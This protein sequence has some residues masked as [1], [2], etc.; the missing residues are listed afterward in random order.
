MRTLLEYIKRSGLKA[1]TNYEFVV[2]QV[3]VEEMVTLSQLHQHTFDEIILQ[4]FSAHIGKSCNETFQI[5]NMPMTMAKQKYAIAANA[6]ASERKYSNVNLTEE[7]EKAGLMM[8]TIRV[9]EN[10]RIVQSMSFENIDYQEVYDCDNWTDSRLYEIFSNRFLFVVYKA[11]GNII[12]H[13][14]GEEKEYVLDDV[15]FWT[16]PQ[17]D[18][19]L[20]EKY[21]NDIRKHVLDDDITD[22]VFWKLKDKRKFHVRPKGR[23]GADREI[24][25]K[26]GKRTAD[27]FCY[28]FNNDYVLNIVNNHKR[29]NGK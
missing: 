20:A 3:Q 1:T 11:T 23:K 26:T 22:G 10:G 16:M 7:F 8:K 4:R 24:S 18:L 29:N 13:P 14:E 25:P 19:S 2:P 9:E 27:K 12:H 5:F 15:F 6:I 21:W 17:D 28:W